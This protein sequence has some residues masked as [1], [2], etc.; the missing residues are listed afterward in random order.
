MYVYEDKIS[1]TTKMKGGEWCAKIEDGRT[2]VQRYFTR[3]YI[4]S[5]PFIYTADPSASFVLLIVLFRTRSFPKVLVKIEPDS[6]P[7]DT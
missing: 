3:A 6:S 4:D 1:I 5:F 2:K 7:A